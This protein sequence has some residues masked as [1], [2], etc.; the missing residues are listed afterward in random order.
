MTTRGFR[1]TIFCLAVFLAGC[2]SSIYSVG[3]EPRRV[4]RPVPRINVIVMPTE[5]LDLHKRRALMTPIFM[6]GTQEGTW[7]PS[8]TNLVRAILLQEG[9]FGTLELF[10]ANN[11]TEQVML[12]ETRDRG[13][14]YLVQASM[15]AIIEPSGDSEGWVALYLKVIS[16]K[17]G[18]SV[19]QIYGEAQLLPQPTVHSL[20]GQQ[21]FVPAPSVGQGIVSITRTMA[22]VMR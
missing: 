12:K 13:L 19:W 22:Q 9:L 20:F 17:R 8:V 3:Q 21:T 18:Y 4:K 6:A 1:A 16:A 10:P 2:S 14:D 11:L 7:G 15:P 5:H